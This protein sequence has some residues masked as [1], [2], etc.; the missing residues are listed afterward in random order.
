MHNRQL[1]ANV[2]RQLM[3][4]FKS[5]SNGLMLDERQCMRIHILVSIMQY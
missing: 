5:Q 1:A 3:L 2:R 4:I